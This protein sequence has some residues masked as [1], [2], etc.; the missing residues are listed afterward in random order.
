MNLDNWLGSEGS[1]KYLFKKGL[2]PSLHMCVS[3]Y[4]AY[5]I[6]SLVASEVERKIR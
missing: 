6:K 5:V 3:M 4:G 2:W 1:P